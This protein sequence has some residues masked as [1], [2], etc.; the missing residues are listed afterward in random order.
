MTGYRDFKI[1]EI[2]WDMEV[3]DE[4]EG[5]AE[6]PSLPSSVVLRVYD[7][8]EPPEDADQLEDWLVDRLSDEFGWCV[9]GCTIELN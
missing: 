7:G 8:D 3:D 6:P 1:S 2:E 4:D 5:Q 9:N